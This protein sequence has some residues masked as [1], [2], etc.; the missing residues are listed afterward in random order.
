MIHRG[1]RADGTHEHWCSLLTTHH[2]TCSCAHKPTQEMIDHLDRKAGKKHSTEGRVLTTLTEI[3]N[4][5]RPPLR[6]GITVCVTS[7]PAR[8]TNGLLQRAISSV[9]NQ[10][11]LPEALV[12]VNDVDRNGAGWSRQRV[13]EQVATEWVAW[14][15]SDDEWMPEHLEKLLRVAVE[16]E[17]VYV[18]SW[19]VGG[20]PLGH[21]GL[22]FNPCT[23]HHTTITSLVRTDIAQEVGFPATQAD[24][25]FSNEDWAFITGVS[26]LA[27]ERGLKMVHL[28]ERTWYY[29]QGNYNS[30]G[31][32]GQGDA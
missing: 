16:T 10:T 28:A 14:I 26:K 31:K 30:S 3:L 24:G 27:C 1:P 5:D 23:P 7:H 20:D 12:L 4:M 21:F 15:D 2:L 13:L 29:H 25:T 19:F 32:P 6:P 17:A 11:R 8:F 18:Y 9:L 22:P